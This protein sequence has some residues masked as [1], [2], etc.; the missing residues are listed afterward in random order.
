MQ[1]QNAITIVHVMAGMRGMYKLYV[2]YLEHGR[3][4]CGEV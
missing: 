2:C 1:F 4:T 3:W